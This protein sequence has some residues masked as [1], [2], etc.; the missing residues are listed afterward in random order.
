MQLP[1][2]ERSLEEVEFSFPVNHHC[3]LKLSGARRTLLNLINVDLTL[4]NPG[5]AYWFLVI[6]KG[7]WNM[8]LCFVYDGY[9]WRQQNDYITV[10][11]GVKAAD[12]FVCILSIDQLEKNMS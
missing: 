1:I 2:S 12:I 7:P 6:F 3:S 8:M 4:N 5:A 9:I 10:D 11:I